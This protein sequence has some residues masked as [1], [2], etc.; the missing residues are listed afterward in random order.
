MNLGYNITPVSE[1]QA[2]ITRLRAELAK[3]ERE[4]RAWELI[5][6]ETIDGVCSQMGDQYQAWA[7]KSPEP[8]L[9]RNAYATDPVEAV[10][11]AAGEK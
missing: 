10:L 9:K 1:L 7:W 6:N 4:H 11:K 2:E 3:R 8:V 5:R